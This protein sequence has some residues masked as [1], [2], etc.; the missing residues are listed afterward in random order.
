MMARAETCTPDQR[1]LALV[2]AYVVHTSKLLSAFAV[3]C[4]ERLQN[5]GNR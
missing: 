4:E 1:T 5:L 3:Q 2:N